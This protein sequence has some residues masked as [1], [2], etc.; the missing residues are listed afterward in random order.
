[1]EQLASTTLVSERNTVTHRL[2]RE[3]VDVAQISIGGAA[4]SAIGSVTE[5][6]TA[7]F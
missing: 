7:A 5:L 2:S 1:M 3:S 6:Y 4:E